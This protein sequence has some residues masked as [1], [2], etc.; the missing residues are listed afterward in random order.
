MS[1]LSRFAPPALTAKNA[2]FLDF[3]GTLVG[4]AKIPKDVKVNPALVPIIGQLRD[5][6]P[7]AGVQ[8]DEQEK[9]NK[10]R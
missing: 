9:P 10:T 8:P 5:R 3:D 2:L 7:G 6:L 1:D 4:F